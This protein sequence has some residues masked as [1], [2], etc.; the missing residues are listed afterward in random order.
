M[1]KE[2]E[3]CGGCWKKWKNVED[4]HRNGNVWRMIKEME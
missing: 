2:L 4:V 3:E 1:L